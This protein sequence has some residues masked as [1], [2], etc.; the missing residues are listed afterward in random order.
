[1]VVGPDNVLG[2]GGVDLL[3]EW[4]SL[5]ISHSTILGDAFLTLRLQMALLFAVTASD[6]GFAVR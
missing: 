3:V 6:I 1:M 2:D 4:F 5:G